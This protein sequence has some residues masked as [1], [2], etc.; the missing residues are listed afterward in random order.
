MNLLERE[1]QLQGLLDAYRRVATGGGEI[2][3][4]SGE[5]GI[6]KT[7]LIDR[8]LREVPADVPS[9]VVS[10]DGL[11]IPGPFGALFDIADALGPEV[12]SLLEA[13]AP[14]DVILRSVLGAFRAM[15]GTMV[16]VGEDAHWID[17]ATL[18]M[19][20]FLGRR[21]R[22]TRVLFIIAYRDD[23]LGPY[24]PLRRVLGDL[25]NAP[26]ISRMTLPPLSRAAVRA[27]AEGTG[28]DPDEIYELTG[29]NSFLVTE[30]VECGLAIVPE[31]IQDAVL[32]RAA[33]LSPEARAVL[34]A[35]ATIA[36]TVDPWLVES[37]MGGPIEDA[38]EECLAVGILH[39][40]DR[41]IE[42][43][44]GLSRKAIL[45]S[46]SAP[47][48]R[49][50]HQRIM[51]AMHAGGVAE[52]DLGHLA[53]HAEEAGD[54][55][56]ARD[57]ATRAARR[58][59]RFGSHREAAGQF[60]RA[61][62]VADDLA[63]GE[64]ASLMEDWSYECY[65]TG[66]IEQAIRVREDVVRMV[67]TLGDRVRE[68]DNMRWLA[69][70]SWFSGRTREAR[71]YAGDAHAILSGLPPGR[72]LAMTLSTISQ[73]RMLE[74]DTEGAIE[75]GERAIELATT[76]DADDIRAHAMINVGTARYSRGEDAGRVSLDE[77]I[78]IALRIGADDDAVRGIN[79]LAWTAW[80]NHGL[81][82]SGK[83]LEQGIEFA[84]ERDLVAMELYLRMTRASVWLAR[85][86]V[87]EAEE[88]ARS[89]A[90]S[91]ASIAA[92]RVMALV[93]LGRVMTIQ[94]RDGAHHLREA[95][96]LAESIGE[97]QR[98]GPV[99]SARAEAAWLKGDMAPVLGPLRRVHDEAVARGNA[100]VAGELSLWLHRAGQDVSTSG[101]PE[102]FALE[103]SGDACAAATRWDEL[104]FPLESIR[105]RTSSGD[106]DDLRTA[107]EAFESLGA[108]ADAARVARVLRAMGV[109]NVPRGHRP[110][111]RANA[112]HLTSRELDV[113]ALLVEGATNR[114]IAER[115]FL[116]V[117]TAGHHVS[118]ILA[119]LDVASRR[120]A[121]L[122]AIDMGI[123][124]GR[125]TVG[126]K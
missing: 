34:D 93:C 120:E 15:P 8:F 79:N 26:G 62:R 66:D 70:F 28:I 16:M 97:L 105:A 72:E 77:A 51:Q 49:A 46:M 35:A 73:L 96:E 58:A 98:T 114:E 13:Q 22:S 109:R 99:T 19:I 23:H 50:L 47:R 102:V 108:T 119:K 41:V 1:T 29:G 32:A 40:H 31:T 17:E 87:R 113:L 67:R 83:F 9:A 6:G 27:M 36:V 25:A 24:H 37:V 116:S 76:L 65:L 112:A 85:G 4:L 71:A 121:V 60:A 54:P 115:L 12:S 111:T 100:W 39:T 14:R 126:T 18:E 103:I 94:G 3:F 124:K 61:V 42:F 110:E 7:S 44:H 55:G 89:V 64:L 59:A 86:Q 45:E 33:R 104:G 81:P 43:R 82:T 48:R 53:Y 30:V 21:I 122:R 10:C 125:D 88:E 57:F 11:G 5:S 118:A 95:D 117:K 123:V 63:P 90:S 78:R 56:A 91:P 101:M 2:V 106:V 68:A 80:T 74:H 20:R 69:R 107:I 38:I 52:R 84:S 75:W 92:T